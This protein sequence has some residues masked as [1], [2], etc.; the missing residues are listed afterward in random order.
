M[1]DT[2]LALTQIRGLIARISSMMDNPNDH[3]LYFTT[4]SYANDSYKLVILVKELDE[5]L[6]KNT[7]T[8]DRILPLW[9]EKENINRPGLTLQCSECGE[10]DGHFGS[11][12]RKN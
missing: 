4:G 9:W 12:S 2:T 10:W 6:T 11:C 7:S 8:G 3:V 5:Y 1:Y